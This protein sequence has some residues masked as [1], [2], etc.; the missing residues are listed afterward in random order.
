M[1]RGEMHEM[2]RRRIQDVAEDLFLDSTVNRYLNAGLRYMQKE[3]LKLDPEAF[4]EVAQTDIVANQGLY[5][6]PTNMIHEIAFK[7]MGTGGRYIRL[8]R[9]PYFNTISRNS[10]AGAIYC[11]HGA[12]FLISPTPT[13]SVVDG[14][15][16]VHCPTLTMADD[17]DVP[18]LNINIHE[19]VVFSAEVFA[20]GE[21]G[22]GKSV[23]E[24]KAK[25]DLALVVNNL[26]LYY[27]RSAAD[28]QQIEMDS[29]MEKDY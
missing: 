24:T 8:V 10:E 22:E 29:S 17:S 16:L 11:H 12:F 4:F 1:T 5:E 19:G 13:S 9:R 26:P 25:E 18:P 28:V 23:F 27:K 7:I 21:N 20:R 14:I 2:F 6:K 15:E 3:V